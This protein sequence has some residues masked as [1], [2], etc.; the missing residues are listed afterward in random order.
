[1]RFENLRFILSLVT[2]S[3]PHHIT[4]TIHR[5]TETDAKCT[6]TRMYGSTEQQSPMRCLSM[7]LRVTGSGTGGNAGSQVVLLV[8]RRS[9]GLLTQVVLPKN[10]R[11]DQIVYPPCVLLRCI[12]YVAKVVSGF[13][14]SGWLIVVCQ[15]HPD[16]SNSNVHRT[17]SSK[18]GR[19]GG[20]NVR[21]LNDVAG[22]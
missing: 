5:P 11:R 9:C 18:V 20:P 3:T 19:G 16:E 21:V 10:K 2:N 8:A 15:G 17:I 6:R 1:M 14:I 7:S 22:C 13:W 12:W 4:Y